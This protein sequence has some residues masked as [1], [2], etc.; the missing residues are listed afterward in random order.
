MKNRLEDFQPNEEKPES[1]FDRQAKQKVEELREKIR[2]LHGDIAATQA[3]KYFADTEINKHFS[4]MGEILQIFLSVKTM[5]GEKNI[6]KEM[7]DELWDDLGKA[8][9]KI[10]SLLATK[11]GAAEVNKVHEGE[12]TSLQQRYNNAK[13]QIFPEKPGEN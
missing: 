11:K 12:L 13:K 4:T 8:M 10:D 3:Q 6:S 1:E 9:A 7:I 2:N 5:F